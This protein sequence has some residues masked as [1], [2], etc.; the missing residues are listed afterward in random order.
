MVIEYQRFH[1][2]IIKLKEIKLLLFFYFFFY[3]MTFRRL[4]LDES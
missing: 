1:V 4:N 2:F 3:F